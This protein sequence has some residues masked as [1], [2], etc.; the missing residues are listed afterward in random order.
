MAIFLA[1]CGARR[2]L[3]ANTAAAAAGAWLRF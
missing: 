1:L 2:N 3:Q